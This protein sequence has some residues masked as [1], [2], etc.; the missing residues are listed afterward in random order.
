MLETK[1]AA[2]YALVGRIERLVLL[3]MTKIPKEITKGEELWW[4]SLC[5]LMNEIHQVS[6]DLGLKELSFEWEMM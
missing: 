6:R 3:G 4:N 5:S 1:R 2:D